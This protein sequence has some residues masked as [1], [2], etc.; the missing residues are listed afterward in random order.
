MAENSTIN[1]RVQKAQSKFC[2]KG[3]CT[4]ITNHKHMVEKQRWTL[5]FKGRLTSRFAR[6]VSH[7]KRLDHYGCNCLCH[8]PNRAANTDGV[9]SGNLWDQF[10]WPLCKI[11]SV[12]YLTDWRQSSKTKETVFHPNIC[13]LSWRNVVCC[14]VTVQF[15]GVATLLSIIIVAGQLSA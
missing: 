1:C 11:S 10:C 13:T 14:C 7:W 6:S 2:Q 4:H 12:R 8:C 15:L 3:S 5:H 9:V